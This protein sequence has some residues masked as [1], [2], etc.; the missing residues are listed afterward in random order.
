MT[1]LRTMRWYAPAGAD[2]TSDHPNE[3]NCPERRS[4]R[5]ANAKSFVVSAARARSGLEITTAGILPSRSQRSG[6]RMLVASSASAW[7]G[8]FVNRWRWPIT[9]HPGGD[10]GSRCGDRLRVV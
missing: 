8:M 2:V 9:G 10:G 3:R 5:D 4:G 1:T 7:W 6:A